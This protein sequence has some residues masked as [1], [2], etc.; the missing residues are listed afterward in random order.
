MDKILILFTMEGCPYCDQMKEKLVQEN[1]EYYERDI[2]QYKEEYDLF[3]E[4]TNNDY[5]PSFMIIDE[6]DNSKSK[7]F[8]PDRDFN[9][10]NEGVEIIKEN[11]RIV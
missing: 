7:L 1:I 9:E 6:K 8:A 10:I 5:V 3:V 4:I 2:D 11:F